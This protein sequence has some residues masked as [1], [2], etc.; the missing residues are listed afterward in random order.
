[1]NFPNISAAFVI[2]KLKVIKD[3]FR[4]VISF[5]ISSDGPFTQ[6]V[7]RRGLGVFLILVSAVI[8]IDCN[9]LWLF[10]KSPSITQIIHPQPAIASEVYSEDGV[11]L[12]KYFYENRV[13]VHFSQIS[14]MLIKT[15]VATEDERFYKHLGIDLIG[16]IAALGDIIHGDPRGA[17]TITQQLVKNLYKTRTRSQLGFAGHIPFLRTFVAKLK[18]MIIAVK[19]EILFDKNDIVTL[20]LNTVDFGN[21]TFGIKTA[22]KTYFDTSP[23]DLKAEQCALLVGVLKATTTYNPLRNRKRALERRNVVLGIMKNHQIITDAH[24]ETLKKLPLKLKWSPEKVNNGSAFYFRQAL[25]D[26]L[27]PWMKKNKLDLYSDGLKIHTSVNSKMQMYAENAVKQNMKRLQQVFNEH[28]AGQHPWVDDKYREIPGFVDMIMSQS[29][30]YKKLKDVYGSNPDSLEYY[31]TRKEKRSLFSWKGSFDS[32]ISLRGMIQYNLRFLHAGFVALDPQTGLVKSWVGGIDF[33][34]FMFDN[35]YQSRRQPGSTFK[36]FVYTAAIDNG[37]SPCDSITD[38][39]VVI[40]YKENGEKKNWAPHNADWVFSQEKVTLK[41][42]FARSLNSVSVQLTE[43]LGWKKVIEYARKMGIASTLD[44]VPSIC[45]GV[46]DVSL[47]ELVSAYCPIANG[48]SRVTPL[49]VTK[50]EDRRGKVLATFKP[51]NE[52]CLDPVTTFLMQQLFLGTMTEPG[53]TTQALYSYDLFRYKTDIGGKTGTSSNHSDGWFV[54]ITP[55]L[56]GGA[57]VGGEHRCIHFKTSALGEGCKTALPIFGSFFE[58][59]LVDT[60]LR[61]IRGRF[62]K[63][64]VPI[65]REYKCTTPVPEED[66]TESLFDLLFSKKKIKD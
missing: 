29:W 55:N 12:G 24:F 5:F 66:T 63:P 35:V 38:R 20:Y 22:A 3:S 10:G 46:S 16:G 28:W 54:G 47:L 56:V 42:A 31:L 34:H 52:K 14:P 41:Y 49:L 53:G 60:S 1:M 43:K 33:T 18:E 57:W 61:Y 26:H 65:T 40:Q 39:P 17:S 21:N 37:F 8:A 6:K 45:L 27:K 23:L 44:T 62:V 7:L 59:V 58:K 30:E 32:T 25:V 36:A 64:D 51:H 13:P 2:E 19:I 15:L 9:F 11:L 50:I 48:G 4:K